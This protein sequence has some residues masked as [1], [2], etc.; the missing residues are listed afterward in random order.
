MSESGHTL[1]AD[2]ERN[3][4]RIVDAAR[5]VFAGQGLD[6]PMSEVARRANVGIAT[7]YRRFPT[8]EDLI[9]SVFAEKMAAYAAAMDD[10]LADP[11]PWHAF[12]A[13]VERSAPCRL[14]T[15]GSPRS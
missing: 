3:R 4:L 8:R 14:R 13:Y 15:A 1:R 9:T 6:A 7:L 11:D 10:A 12:C 5:E 2:A